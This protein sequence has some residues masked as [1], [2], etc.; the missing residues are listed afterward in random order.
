MRN[1][2]IKI[3]LGALLI[4]AVGLGVVEMARAAKSKV[5]RIAESA[6]PITLPVA[7]VPFKLDGDRIGTIRKVKLFRSSPDQISHVELTVKLAD[8]ATGQR[9]ADCLLVARDMQRFDEHST[10]ACGTASDTAG[11]A[12]VPFVH[13]VLDGGDGT[14]RMVY[15][16]KRDADSIASHDKG[17]KLT[18]AEEAAIE[19][20]ADS[21]SAAAEAQAERLG[22]QLEAQAE[23]LAAL[24]EAQSHA[25]ELKRDSLRAAIERQVD[26]IR[27]VAE[28][29]AEAARS[30]VGPKVTVKVN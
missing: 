3:A 6:D 2:W 15:I 27:A 18:P 28:A 4:F 17:G 11:G 12:M 25:V 1:Y 29:R 8:E 21:I 24:H 16:P 30:R 26:S 20:Q 5:H 7:F 10:F 22:A 9:L 14:Q 19:A 13:V 23:S